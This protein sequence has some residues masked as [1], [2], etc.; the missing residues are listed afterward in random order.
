MKD[1]CPYCTELAELEESKRIEPFDIR[2]EKIEVEVDALKCSECGEV[3]DNPRAERDPYADAY[4]EYR[5]RHDLLQPEEIK[6]FRERF[7]LSQKE[8]SKLLGIGVATLNRYENGSLQSEAHER[9]IRVFMDDPSHFLRMLH[10]NPEAILNSEKRDKLIHELEASDSDNVLEKCFRTFVEEYEP[11]EFSGYKNLE[12]N[13]IFNVILFF[14]WGSIY[15]TALNKHLFYADFKHFKECQ[16][17]ITGLRY[18]HLPY[19]PVPDHY[20]HYYNIMEERR[21]ISINEI[22]IGNYLAEEYTAIQK[23]D[24]NVFSES[25]LVVLSAIKEKMRSYGSKYISDL[26]HKE[27]AYAKTRDNEFIPY[28]YATTLSI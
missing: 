21:M 16:Y 3:F 10:D 27:D 13:K 4:R 7:N 14:C 23:P 6:A 12:I 22:P 26:S 20:N 8:L 17:S 28:T 25:E 24:L 5:R 15:K 2:G 11:N 18:K 19:G 9:L 1:L